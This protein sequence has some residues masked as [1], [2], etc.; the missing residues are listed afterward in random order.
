MI[1][2]K[3][4]WANERND[5]LIC[6]KFHKIYTKVDHLP[7]S[8]WWTSLKLTNLGKVKN[9]HKCHKIPF[10]ARISGNVDKISTN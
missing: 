4:K 9:W 2:A 8:K 7:S 1:K 3:E 6:T 5:V 10:I